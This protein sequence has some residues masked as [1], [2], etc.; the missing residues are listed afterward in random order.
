MGLD[1][2]IVTDNYEDLVAGDYYDEN[3]D[4]FHKRHLSRTFCDLMCR[5]DI[6]DG[7]PELNQIG[8]LVDVDISCF[9]TMEKYW[10]KWYVEEHLLHEK[11]ESA[12]E[13]FLKRVKEDN[14]RLLG[15]IVIVKSTVD[16]LIAMLSSFQNLE[17]EVDDSN[18]DTLGNQYYFS[19]FLTDKGDGYIENNFGQDLRNFQRFL[20]FAQ[21][22]GA[23]TVWFDYG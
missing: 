5:K 3:N 15:N 18:N 20:N 9:Y 13:E 4:Y 2:R 14:E 11:S 6:I 17:K 1:I 16:S 23:T 12:K 22:K 21:S 19:D 10:D 8:K 7:E